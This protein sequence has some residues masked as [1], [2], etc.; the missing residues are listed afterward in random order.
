MTFFGFKNHRLESSLRGDFQEEMK[1]EK[2][3]HV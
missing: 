2:V 1:I 3:A